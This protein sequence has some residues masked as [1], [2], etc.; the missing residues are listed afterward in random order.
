MIS[1]QDS[2]DNSIKIVKKYKK[3]L[4]QIAR[5]EMLD[6]KLTVEEMVKV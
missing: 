4:H 1:D 6:R 3:K 2:L 5:L